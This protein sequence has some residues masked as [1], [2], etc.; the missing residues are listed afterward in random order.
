MQSLGLHSR[1]VLYLL[2]MHI[3][4]LHPSQEQKIPVAWAL[5]LNHHEEQVSMQKVCWDTLLCLEN[6][7]QPVILVMQKQL[8]FKSGLEAHATPSEE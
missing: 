7:K 1:C 4:I 8:S 5:A 6:W 2:V 3:Q